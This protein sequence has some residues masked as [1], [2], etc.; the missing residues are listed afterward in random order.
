M[1]QPE[2]TITKLAIGDMGTS[3]QKEQQ[4]ISR[5]GQRAAVLHWQTKKKNMTLAYDCLTTEWQTLR[6]WQSQIE[7][8]SGKEFSLST[9]YSY[10]RQSEAKQEEFMG[11]I[12]CE[13]ETGSRPGLPLKVRKS[14]KV[15]AG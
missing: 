9:V 10:A 12:C 11:M 5:Y 8:I 15:I 4:Y 7:F 14:R 13:V 2:Y 1:L 3:Y 6:E